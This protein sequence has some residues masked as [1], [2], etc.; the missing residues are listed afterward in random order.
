MTA[1]FQAVAQGA[2]PPM[3]CHAIRSHSGAY[4]ALHQSAPLITVTNT[5]F[6]VIQDAMM[7]AQDFHFIRGTFRVFC[8]SVNVTAQAAP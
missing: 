4:L 6:T 2:A 1:Q 3:S 5:S 7:I 8:A